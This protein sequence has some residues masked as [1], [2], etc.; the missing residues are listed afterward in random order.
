MRFA[1]LRAGLL[2]LSVFVSGCVSVEEMAAR[3]A[4]IE[5]VTEIRLPQGDGPFPAVVVL[6]NCAGL[7]GSGRDVPLG[8]ADFLVANG[9]AVALT[10]SFR[11][12]N[13]FGGVCTAPGPQWVRPMIRGEDAHKGRRALQANPKVDRNRIAVMGGSNGGV[14]T[15]A[16]VNRQWIEQGG[17][18]RAGEAQFRAAIPFYPECGIGYGDWVV[19]RGLG[20]VRPSGTFE[21]VAPMLILIGSA[22]D[23]TPAPICETMAGQASGAP[24]SIKVYPGAHHSF[25]NPTLP[26][27]LH[28]PRATNINRP[29]AGATV[30]YDPAAYVD[31][32]AQVLRFLGEHMRR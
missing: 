21:S 6:H 17:W 15:L 7:D 25:D 12:R 8:W 31:S 2:L 9:Y 27:A 14:A 30:G 11:P 3:D 10:D 19:Q 24:V 32:K 1:E 23:W 29:G 18:L 4:A 22:D 13:R 26:R 16:A 20:G 28:N 5:P